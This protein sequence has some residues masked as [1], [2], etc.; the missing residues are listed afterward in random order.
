MLEWKNQP[1]KNGQRKIQ[2]FLCRHLIS[3]LYR[4]TPCSLIG[5]LYYKRK[6]C[7]YN[8]SFYELGNGNGTCY[9]WDETQGKRGS[10]EVGTCVY[11]YV[12]SGASDTSVIEE[13]TLYSDT[14]GR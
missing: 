1:I 13:V 6:L 12:T 7:C 5:E 3:R 10:C 14:C 4:Q 11:L 2:S 8:L 9:L